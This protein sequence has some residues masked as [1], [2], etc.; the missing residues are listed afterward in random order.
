MRQGRNRS[1][2]LL[3]SRT[4]ERNVW[5]MRN[6][7]FR[8]YT[9]FYVAT[10]NF[11]VSVYY[12]VTEIDT[13]S[14]KKAAWK[15]AKTVSFHASMFCHT[16]GVRCQLLNGTNYRTAVRQ[17]KY[18]LIILHAWKNT[19]VCSFFLAV[20]ELWW[21]V[22]C[23][24]RVSL[25]SWRNRFSCEAGVYWVLFASFVRESSCLC[26]LMPRKRKSITTRRNRSKSAPTVLCR[27][28]KRR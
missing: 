15:S 25:K 2:W 27:G 4:T 22:G 19:E 10:V 3:G 5:W 21:V 23:Q 26:V 12:S 6:A 7:T 11:S 13:C 14:C 1:D 8:E 28:S 9:I 24:E 17:K 18:C 16:Y 20:F